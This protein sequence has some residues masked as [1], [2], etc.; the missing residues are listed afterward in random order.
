MSRT[1]LKARIIKMRQHEKEL[2]EKKAALMRNEF[3][4]P[5]M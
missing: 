2:I 4:G 5:G 3:R 1:A